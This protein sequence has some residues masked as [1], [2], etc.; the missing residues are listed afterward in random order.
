MIVSSSTKLT[1]NAAPA[2][3]SDRVKQQ[4]AAKCAGPNATVQNIE[5][6][7]TPTFTLAPQLLD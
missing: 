5:A 1:P 3:V 6:S 2:V 7:S 4:R